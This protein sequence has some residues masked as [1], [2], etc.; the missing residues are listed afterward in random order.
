VQDSGRHRVSTFV[1]ALIGSITLVVTIAGTF[2]AYLELR[3]NQPTTATWVRKSNAACDQDVGSLYQSVFNGLAPSTVA[4]GDSS[5]QSSQ[6]NKI[7]ALIGAVSSLSKLVGDLGALPTPQDSRA[8]QVQAVLNSGNALVSSL[9]TFSNAAQAAV[10]NTP[11]TTFSQDI[12]TELKAEKQFLRNVVAWRKAIGRL[13][14]TRCPFWI[15]NP[16]APP[17]T[18]P[19]SPQPTS[20]ASLTSGEQ[21]LVNQLNSNYLTNCY[22]RPDLEGVG[23][24]VAAVNCRNVEAGPTKQPLVVK[25]S[26]IGSALA[27]FNNNTVG[28]VDR[29]DC[30]DGYK[31][32][33]WTH[34]YIVAGVLG[35]AY[36]GNGDFRMVWV[37]DSALIGVIADGSYGPAMNEWWTNSAYVVYGNE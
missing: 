21:Q 2:I 22:G 27:W 12:A 4:E 20:P 26:D 9:V 24:I 30:A 17:P 31:L 29:D 1:K 3:Q 28:F 13:G 14:L 8:P 23:G 10:E 15:S 7:H 6:V 16:N 5:D 36:T 34:N 37:I 18:L 25:F 19:P 35:C 33:T 11:G 32:G